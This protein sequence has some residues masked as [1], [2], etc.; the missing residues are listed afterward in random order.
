MGGKLKKV[1]PGSAKKAKKVSTL[2]D[3]IVEMCSDEEFLKA[4]GFDEAV[5]GVDDKSRRL[6][7]SIKKCI[8]ILNSRDGMTN[9]EAVE[10]FD[11]NVSGAYVGEKT[12]IWCQDDF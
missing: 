4:D 11:Y 2:L 3:K 7:Y 8:E 6:V 5:I 10:Y 1:K 12:P 9:E